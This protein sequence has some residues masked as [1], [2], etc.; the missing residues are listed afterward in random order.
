MTTTSNITTARRAT[1]R[2]RHPI[3]YYSLMTVI[4]VIALMISTAIVT[5]TVRAVV[6]SHLG[7][8][9]VI[10]KTGSMYQDCTA[11]ANARGFAV[12]VC[13]SLNPDSTVARTNCAAEIKNH[14]DPID[15]P[16]IKH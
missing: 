12:D 4:G 13:E 9:I 5:G 11:F 3:A 8:Q 15:C 6:G 14:A 1:M 7:N 10:E 2:S 16:T